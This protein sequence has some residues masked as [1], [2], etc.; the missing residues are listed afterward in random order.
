MIARA[1][2]FSSYSFTAA[3]LKNAFTAETPSLL[4]RSFK[5]LHCCYVLGALV[6]RVRLRPASKTFI[7]SILAIR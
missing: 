2:T 7:A 3:A 1:L 4:L 5:L 6:G